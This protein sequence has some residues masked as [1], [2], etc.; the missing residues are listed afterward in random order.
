MIKLTRVEYIAL[1]ASLHRYEEVILPYLLHDQV[2]PYRIASTRRHWLAMA[3]IMLSTPSQRFVSPHFEDVKLI[4][5]LLIPLGL[6]TAHR[7]TND[8]KLSSKG[9]DLLRAILYQLLKESAANKLK[10]HEKSISNTNSA[11]EDIDM[12]ALVY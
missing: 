2:T 4:N 10:P 3:R 6:V 12:S 11:I 1:G 8:V 5:R 9:V 7:I